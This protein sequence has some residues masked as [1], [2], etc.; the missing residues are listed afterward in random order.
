MIEENSKQKNIGIFFLELILVSFIPFIIWWS[1]TPTNVLNST[2]LFGLLE[3]IGLTGSM[4]LFLLGIPVGIIGIK[5]SKKLEK[6]KNIT[7]ILS[8][9]NLLAGITEITTLFLI[10]LCSNI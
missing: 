1:K 4:L 8:L 10:I 6:H 2:P 5:K 9:I 7:I 3:K